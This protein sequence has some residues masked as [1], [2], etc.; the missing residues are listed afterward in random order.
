MVVHY[1]GVRARPA[2]GACAA[3]PDHP[4]D[5]LTDE[6]PY[7][8]LPDAAAMQLCGRATPLCEVA[9]HSLRALICRL[10]LALSQPGSLQVVLVCVVCCMGCAGQQVQKSLCVFREDTLFI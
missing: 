3:A 10:Q 1:Q 9:W 6:R 4:V 5:M 2:L 8:R 7:S